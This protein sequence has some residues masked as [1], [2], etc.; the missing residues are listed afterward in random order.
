[1]SR[2]Q[3]K[4]KAK[5]YGPA[6][7]SSTIYVPV[8]EEIV[9]PPKK[10]SIPFDFPALRAARRKV[11]AAKLYKVL[12]KSMASALLRFAEDPQSPIPVPDSQSS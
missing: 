3:L 8:M 11:W 12:K 10:E 6:S 9:D 5:A 7:S 2:K 1:M 4:Y